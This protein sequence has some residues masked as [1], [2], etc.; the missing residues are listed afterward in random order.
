[1]FKRRFYTLIAT[2]L[3]RQ[4]VRPM[5]KGR[6]PKKGAHISCRGWK[7]KP[8]RSAQKGLYTGTIT[9]VMRCRL[10]VCESSPVLSIRLNSYDLTADEIEQFALNDGFEN[11]SE[12]RDV[13]AGMFGLPFYGLA[14]FWK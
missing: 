11:A 7:G 5:P 9:A 4:T 13:F 10:W 8:Y 12:M 2:G 6:W 14:I 3:K 1:M